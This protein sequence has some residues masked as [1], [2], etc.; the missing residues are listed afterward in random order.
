MRGLQEAVE[1]TPPGP[2]DIAT[3]PFKATT[4]TLAPATSSAEV[5]IPAPGWWSFYN[6]TASDITIRFYNLAGVQGAAVAADWAIPPGQIQQF[7]IGFDPTAVSSEAQR[8][9]RAF[10]TPGGNLK[11]YKSSR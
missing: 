2:S 5:T 10:S 1:L 9:W 11:Y 7:Y 4:L 3:D 8:Y 6:T